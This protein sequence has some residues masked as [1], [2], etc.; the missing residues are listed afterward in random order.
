M[1]GRLGGPER[2]RRFKRRTARQ[3]AGDLSHQNGGVLRQRE[4]LA[5]PRPHLLERG[6]VLRVSLER[7]PDPERLRH[8]ACVAARLPRPE[9]L[10]VLAQWFLPSLS[11]HDNTPRQGLTAGTPLL[12][13]RPHFSSLRW[14]SRS[15]GK[16]AG[17]GTGG[18]EQD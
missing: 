16:S 12:W 8:R 7:R 4:A 11:P 14:S 17:G 1:P 15:G 10:L 9:G 13:C 5:C 6:G 18:A 2:H 3:A